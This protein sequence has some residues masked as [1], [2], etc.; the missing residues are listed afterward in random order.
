MKES[1]TDQVRKAI[2]TSGMS[3]YRICKSVGMDQAA[4]SRFMA[5][6]G[7]FSLQTL[8]QLAALLQL[9]IRTRKDR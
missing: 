7:G 2:D 4:M 9:E 3:R 1:L 5:G 8:D 6:K